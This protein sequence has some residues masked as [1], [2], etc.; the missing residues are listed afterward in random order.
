M[1]Q[2]MEVRTS[3]Y[4]WLQYRLALASWARHFSTMDCH[5]CSPYLDSY[6]R[7]EILTS[8]GDHQGLVLTQRDSDLSWRI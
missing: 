4:F 6:G 1:Y 3:S 8:T 2:G 5:T 7:M